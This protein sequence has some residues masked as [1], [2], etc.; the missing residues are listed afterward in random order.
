[1]LKHIISRSSR[2]YEMYPPSAPAYMPWHLSDQ[3]YCTEPLEEI[4]WTFQNENL[5]I[6]PGK[7]YKKYTITIIIFRPIFSQ[8]S[9]F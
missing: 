2:P 6:L 9:L 8:T 5:F 3:M 7:F 4:L 1:M